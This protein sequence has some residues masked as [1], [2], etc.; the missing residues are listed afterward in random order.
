MTQVADSV[1]EEFCAEVA[2]A[3][4]VWALRHPTDAAVYSAGAG[5]ETTLA[6]WSS[7][8]RAKRYS[9]SRDDLRDLRPLEIDWPI[10]CRSWVGSIV[11]TA[12]EIGVNWSTSQPACHATTEE[13]IAGVEKN[14]I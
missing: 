4:A 3:N 9:N 10:F 1:L 5:T 12:T 6:F 13:I 11:P 2:R 8:E 14:A 7:R